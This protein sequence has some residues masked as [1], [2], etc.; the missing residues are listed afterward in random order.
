MERARALS[1][2]GNNTFENEVAEQNNFLL[3]KLPLEI[4][5]MVYAEL[6]PFERVWI[7]IIDK[8]LVCDWEIVKTPISQSHPSGHLNFGISNPESPEELFRPASSITPAQESSLLWNAAS[9]MMSRRPRQM[10]LRF[11]LGAA[12]KSPIWGLKII[13]FL[14]TCRRVYSEVMPYLYS[15]PTFAFHDSIPFLTFVASIPPSHFQHIRSVTIN[16]TS[17]ALPRYIRARLERAKMKS[18]HV[19]RPRPDVCSI[20]YDFLYDGWF[21]KPLYNTSVLLPYSPNEVWPTVLWDVIAHVL[22]EMKSL[23]K[24]H[25]TLKKIPRQI[26]FGKGREYATGRWRDEREIMDPLA[27]IGRPRPWKGEVADP[28]KEFETDVVFKTVWPREDGEEKKEGYWVRKVGENGEVEW[29]E[30][31]EAAGKVVSLDYDLISV[32]STVLP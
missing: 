31:G 26:L 10:P 17:L 20:S 3:F 2:C 29:K 24:V 22:Q 18:L 19:L 7:V 27:W 8:Q 11:R 30:V 16:M 5:E 28:D 21:P 13:P 25:I 14:Q 23:R 15:K 1:I 4:R 32:R 12:P 9:N 6:L